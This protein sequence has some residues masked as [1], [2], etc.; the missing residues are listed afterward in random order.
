MGQLAPGEFVEHVLS[1]LP[2]DQSITESELEAIYGQSF[3]ANEGLIA[4]IDEMRPAIEVILLSNTNHLDIRY[5]ENRFNLISWADNAV[6]SYKVHMRKPD[7]GIYYHTINK[8]KLNLD[9]TLFI[10]D[11]DENIHG[12]RTTGLNAE[13]YRSPAQVEN[14]LV[15]LTG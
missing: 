2:T 8:F 14:M 1:E 3:Q 4:V 6:L 11:L 5:I 12:A 13:K 10:D 7:P 15:Q 9:K